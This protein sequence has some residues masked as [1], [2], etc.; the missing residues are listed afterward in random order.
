MQRNGAIF[1]FGSAKVSSPSMIETYFS[2]SKNLLLIKNTLLL[3][4]NAHKEIR[5][6]TIG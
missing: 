6:A 2:Y 5:L 4:Q 1:N 3:S